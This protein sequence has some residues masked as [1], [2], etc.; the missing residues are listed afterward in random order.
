MKFKSTIKILTFFL[1]VYTLS[2]CLDEGP[3]NTPPDASGAIIQMSF[4]A[5][6]GNLVNSGIRY[7]GA[8]ALTYPP[9]DEVDTATFAVTLQGVDALGE[10]VAVTL[11]TPADALDDY[12]Y[13]D[14]IGYEMM[15]D[16]L[17][18]FVGST[19]G[20]IKAGE[21]YA[22]FKVRFFPSKMDLKKNYMLPV[23][24]TNSANLPTSSNYGY[25]YFHAIGNPIGGIY[26]WDFQR[27]DCQGGPG[28]CALNAGASFT[29]EDIVF[30]PSNG[31]SIKVPTGYY[32]QPNYLI[33]FKDDG[34]VLSDF[35]AEIAPDEIKGAF[36]DNGVTVVKSPVIAVD[37]TTDPAHPVYTVTY[38][39]FNGSAYRYCID[40]YTKQ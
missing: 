33:S 25:V 13:A 7:F 11:T 12:F 1:V 6:G 40:T 37:N 36:T 22:E 35:K 3:M 17:Y 21:S 27:Y 24:A 20:V 8:Q 31:T 32:V 2:S 9:T 34:V 23:T 5:N 38:T 10:D 26:T 28:A 14:S 30:A 15:P 29:G 39:V 16:S 18:E 19:S 4:N